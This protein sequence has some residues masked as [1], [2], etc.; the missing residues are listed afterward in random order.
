M[1]RRSFLTNGLTAATVVA[2]GTSVAR[3]AEP[4]KVLK[5]IGISCSPRKGKTTYQGVTDIV[6]MKKS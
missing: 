4:S 5:I 1:D 3:A 2:M 6:L